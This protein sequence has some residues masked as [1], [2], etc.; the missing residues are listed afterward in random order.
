MWINIKIKINTKNE[1]YE[2]SPEWERIPIKDKDLE[3]EIS[4]DD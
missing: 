4:Q 2:L 1:E 3:I